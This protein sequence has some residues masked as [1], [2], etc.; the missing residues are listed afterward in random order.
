MRPGDGY[1]ERVEGS[2]ENDTRLGRCP[3]AVAGI[4]GGAPVRP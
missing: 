2:D 3:D 4:R 1:R